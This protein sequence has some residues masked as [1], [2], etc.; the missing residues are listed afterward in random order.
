MFTAITP[1]LPDWLNKA[2]NLSISVTLLR[3]SSDSADKLAANA[4]S[5]AEKLGHRESM[6]RLRAVGGAVA[7]LGSD[8]AGI[9]LRREL[10]VVEILR[11]HANEHADL[12]R[13]VM[14]YL[15]AM[16][17][18]Q[19][20]LL[21][22]TDSAAE[23]NISRPGDA[24]KQNAV[25]E[26]LVQ[27]ATH[28]KIGQI[29]IPEW[30]RLTRSNAHGSRIV[31]AA[32]DG[33]CKIYEGRNLID[34][35]SSNGQMLTAMK[36][37]TA[38][39]ERN[40]IVERQVRGTLGKLTRDEFAWPYSPSLLPPGYAI[41]ERMRTK[42]EGRSIRVANVCADSMYTQGWTEFF[43]AVANGVP[44]LQAGRVLAKHKIPCRGVR[45]ANQTYDQLTD[46]QLANAARTFSKRRI[47]KMLRSRQYIANVSV[48]VKLEAGEQFNGHDVT[49]LDL[50]NHPNGYV[51]VVAQLPEHG[52]ELSDSEWVNWDERTSSRQSREPR[53][54][55]PR[56]ALVGTGFWR[57]GGSDYRITCQGA[58]PWVY[59][60]VEFRPVEQSVDKLGND[61]GWKNG[62][63]K[64]T[65]TASACDVEMAL[66]RAIEAGAMKLIEQTAVLTIL[67][68][69][70]PDER[71]AEKVRKSRM[72]EI[73]GQISDAC[74]DLIDAQDALNRN[75][76][77][78]KTARLAEFQSILNS[79][80]VE[81][82]GLAAF[83]GQSESKLVETGDIE[84]AVEVD[85]SSLASLAG[86]LQGGKGTLMP[87]VV[88]DTIR[89][90]TRGSVRI[91][92]LP[93]NPGIGVVKATIHWPSQDGESLAFDVCARVR[94]ATRQSS[95]D[96]YR[97]AAAQLILEEG[98][99]I[100]Q[101]SELFASKHSRQS[102]VMH[103]FEW[104]GSNGVKDH[105]LRRAI[106]DCPIK[107]TKA[108]AWALLT[109]TAL[110][111]GS[112]LGWDLGT[113]HPTSTH[114]T[115][116]IRL[117]GCSR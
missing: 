45:L 55:V 77:D 31:A 81:K 80:E 52:I 57:N 115:Y 109:H 3:V 97:Y 110:P 108:V 74:E 68:R 62:E 39:A 86:I 79:L 44:H 5:N 72:L 71:A 78:R 8:A 117:V 101:A 54:N 60:K 24:I 84:D 75:P 27:L 15:W 38:S 43:K 87:R 34:F 40:G 85:V 35:L 53:M 32:S 33:R 9:A 100:E 116:G 7:L 94:L 76:T 105:R 11:A 66:G 29:H 41:K 28:P 23:N 6:Q 2:A 73:I 69:D 112:W 48:P 49:D 107:E 36:T 42:D 25:A 82:A 64:F 14:G 21:F 13:K 56:R 92:A 1:I 26:I 61:R 37:A 70:K 90:I 46:S 67:Q 20:L 114:S 95:P 4:D 18:E 65:L 10:G 19:D 88:N 16:E 99:S 50:L 104:L 113:E 12:P 102:V 30:S 17:A 59:Y 106:L 83:D 47:Y 51:G 22:V 98:L 111:K 103:A 96:F 63:G 91:E 89:E 93:E 58:T